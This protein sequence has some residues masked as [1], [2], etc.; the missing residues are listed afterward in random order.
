[1]GL[2]TILRKHRQ[3]EKEMRLLMLG[4]DNAGKTT[5]L[6]RINGDPID[7][8]SP[9]LGFNIKTFEHQGYKLNVWDVGGQTSLRSYWRNYFERTDGLVWVVDAGDHARIA[10]CKKELDNLLQEE[11]LAG[12]SLLV[13]ANKQD[14]S[15]AMT[16]AEIRDALQLDA[17]EHIHLL[18]GLDWLVDEIAS[19]LY[20]LD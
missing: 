13:L 9:T 19:R 20:L 17:I 3:K 18:D 1:M 16:V 15:G 8:I 7:D 5:L 2:L 14:L 12:A 10:D 6:K 11:R 4:L